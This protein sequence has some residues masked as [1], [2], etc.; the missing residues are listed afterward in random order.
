MNEYYKKLIKDKLAK[1]VESHVLTD[2]QTMA[3]IDETLERLVLGDD[4]NIIE[5]VK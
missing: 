5:A 1:A 2:D 3:V 4:K